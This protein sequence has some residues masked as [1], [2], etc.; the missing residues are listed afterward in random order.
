MFFGFNDDQIAFR[1]AVRDL[2]DKECPP[3]VVRAAWEAPAGSL[4][5]GVWDRLDEMGAL[6]TLVPESHGGLGLDERS[7][8]LVL[9]EAGRAGLPHP[10]VETAAV[11]APLVA[12]LGGT[13]NGTAGWAGIGVG[14]DLVASD[15]GARHV[16]C[17]ADADHLLLQD[18]ASGALHLVRP[19]TVTLTPVETVD[20]ARRAADVSWRPSPETPSSWPS[21]EAPGAP[22]PSWSG[23]ASGCWT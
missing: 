9:E 18:P 23:S 16:A 15:L 3:E 11:T 12:S 20:C 6:A 22:R 7:L 13:A 10:L 2:L 1:D 8:V 4:D 19:D 5:R 17:A 14:G 21:T